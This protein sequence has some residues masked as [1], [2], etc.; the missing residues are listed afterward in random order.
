MSKRVKIEGIKGEPIDIPNFWADSIKRKK[1]EQ[2]IK[3]KEGEQEKERVNSIECPVCKSTDKIHH[4]KRDSNG[5]IGPGRSSWIV[6]EYLI[7]KICGVHY[8]D[9]EKFKLGEKWKAKGEI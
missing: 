6:D 5:I 4:I 2:E 3:R 1:Q 9:I 7:C 8:N